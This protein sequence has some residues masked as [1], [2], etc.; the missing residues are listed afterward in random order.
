MR[1]SIFYSSIRSFCVTIAAILGIG[2]GLTL[3][4]LFLGLISGKSQ[5]L[6]TTYTP[7]IIADAEGKRKSLSSDVPVILKLNVTGMIGAGSLTKEAVRQQLVESR[8]DSLKDNRV[9]GI[10]LYI[11]SP[12]GTVVDA[13]GIYH[14]IKTYKEQYKVP[15]YAYIDGLCASGG[16]YVAM[17]ADQIYSSDSSIIGSI[18]VIAPSFFNLTDLLEKIGVQSLTLSAG[19]GKDELNPFRKWK[20]D[21][22]ENVKSLIDYFYNS[23]VD[24]VVRNRPEIN[25]EKLVNDYGANIFNPEQAKEYGFINASGKSYRETLKELVSKLDLKDENYQVIELK[26][27]TWWSELVNGDSALF[28][29]RITVQMPAELDPAMMNQFMYLYKPN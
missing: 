15:V 27:K 5:E 4:I 21:E 9:K 11:N 10:L 22:G 29:G 20:A 14:T 18:G 24:I 12:G 7:E 3:L 23:F 25:K 2:V 17:A 8:E 26:K 6:E 19:K 16:L 13:D 1:D 28:T